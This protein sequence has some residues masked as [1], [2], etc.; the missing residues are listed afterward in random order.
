M[1]KFLLY[2]HGGAYNHG[3]EAILR[4][5][6]P[7]FRRAGVPIFLSTH[8]PEQDREFGLD[9]L[10]DRLV[11][12]D[13]SLVPNERSMIEFEDKE[14]AA[15]Q[16]YRDAL[17]EIDNETVCVGMGGDN[18]CYPNWH[19]QSIFHR[20]AKRR[21][22]KSILWGCSIQPEMIDDRMEEIL[23]EHD[24]IYVRESVSAQALLAHGI[25]KI[26]QLPDPAFFLPP[27]PFPVPK[28]LRGTA[29]AINLSPLVL[30]RSD[31]LLNDFAEA[32]HFLLEKA[33]TLLLLPHV[34]MP[35]DDDQEALD[36]L[37]QCLT[38]EEQ[39]RLCRVPRNLTAAQRKYLIS[40]C[41]L[42]VCCR[43]HASIAGYSAGVPTLVVGYSVKSQGIG[44]DLEMERWVISAENSTELL[45][46]TKELWERRQLIRTCLL[47]KVNE[48][49][50]GERIAYVE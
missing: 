15:A 28:E 36:A 44:L 9:E 12:A 10:V 5:S 8:F 11:P 40:R 16:I 48:L 21:G 24:C 32:A 1:K 50:G 33:D 37:A 22:G 30:R 47:R 4:S 6:L 3:A 43:T 23:R 46:R 49:C 45:E 2:G 19:R 14:R 18:Y 13:L 38:P 31:R 27:A 7:V 42:L 41:E 34:T 29:A 20:T 35:V 25:T 26:I 39:L 17:A